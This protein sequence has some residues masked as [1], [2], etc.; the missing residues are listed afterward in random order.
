[1]QF[2]ATTDLYF[3]CSSMPS[4]VLGVVAAA[5]DTWLVVSNIRTE[6]VLYDLTKCREIRC[7][8]HQHF[9]SSFFVQKSFEQLFCTYGLGLYF[10][11]WQKET[12]AKSACKML[13]KLTLERVKHILRHQYYKTFK[14]FK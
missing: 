1:M 10:C 14:S 6:L 8:F 5:Q 13:V 9:T 7:Q 11:F 4:F 3:L 2:C 12:G